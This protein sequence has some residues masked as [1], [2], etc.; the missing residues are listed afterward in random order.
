MKRTRAST[1]I[2]QPSRTQYYNQQLSVKIQQNGQLDEVDASMKS[3]ILGNDIIDLLK[4][5]K[6]NVNDE[7]GIGIRMAPVFT[8]TEQE[9]QDPM[10]YIQSIY[11]EAS[12][13]G[14][15]KI[16]PPPSFSTQ[17]SMKQWLTDQNEPFRFNTRI[18][19]VSELDG[20]F[21]QSLNFITALARYH[22][23]QRDFNSLKEVFQQLPRLN[24]S[25]L[26]LQ[27]LHNEVDTVLRESGNNS[28]TCKLWSKVAKRFSKFSD[29][30]SLQIIGNLLRQ[31]HQIWIAPFVK[32]LRDR[33]NIEN[34]VN[35]SGLVP[36]SEF[37]QTHCLCYFCDKSTDIND[38]ECANCEQQFHFRCVPETLRQN[39]LDDHW[40]CD[41]CV[42]CVPEYSFQIGQD[43]SL[44]DF[45]DHAQSFAL[46]YSSVNNI[47]VKSEVEIER[48][49]WKLAHTIA[50]STQVMYA[51]D[52]ATDQCGSG[53]PN[54]DQ[55]D[56]KVQYSGW[57]LQN[58][59]KLSLL[60]Y[61]EQDIS[62]M[63]VPWMYIGM[64]FSAFCWHNEDHY[65]YSINYNHFGATK[66]W[67]GVPASDAAKFEQVMREEMP[68]LFA[69][70]PSLL[71]HI[72]TTLD[73]RK[74][75]TKGVS[76]FQINQRPNEFVV[77][78]PRAYHAGFNHGFNCAEAVNFVLPN[79]IPFGRQCLERYRQFRK[80]PVF[81]HDQLILNIVKSNVNGEIPEEMTRDFDL[82]ITRLRAQRLK[83][84]SLDVITIREFEMG[85]NEAQ[86]LA[87]HNC[88][89]LM[90]LQYVFCVQCQTVLCFE[91][92]CYHEHSDHP[93][94]LRQS[95][96][97][98]DFLQQ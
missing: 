51:A 1:S 18:Q 81:S 24:G 55:I 34:C 5:R 13:Y 85:S 95:Q 88:Q 72:T 80:P 17:F 48:E 32:F 63:V 47:D 36:Q 19:R 53:F 56:N 73:P 20:S 46:K 45:Y 27:R 33:I 57:Y 92:N 14:I 65:S 43:M 86:S 91:S 60:K 84:T 62:G 61:V 9:F 67:Y 50:N 98:E 52:L 90:C 49:F 75:T 8:P 97:F 78:F 37:D 12:Q 39:V 74:L 69:N 29:Q 22:L 54:T 94:Q 26:D 31:H 11:K 71:S 23:M 7:S 82:I 30:Q 59:S 93:L 38:E 68:D 25:L 58:L 76:C 3:Q 64:M 15:C 42:C 70:D 44:K 35:V 28:M 66:T 96:K 83:M 21:R 6:Q 16:V 89:Q 2:A 77:T 4:V 79:W 40:Y 10:E 87:C 41:R